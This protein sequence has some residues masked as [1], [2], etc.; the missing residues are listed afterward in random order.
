MEKAENYNETLTR[1]ND[2]LN[3]IDVPKSPVE[4]TVPA[5]TD[6]LGSTAPTPAANSQ[7]S[8]TLNPIYIYGGVPI[9]VLIL[10]LIIQPTFLRDETKDEKGEKKTTLNFKKVVIWTA[11]I[12]TVID[13]GIFAYFYQQKK[14]AKAKAV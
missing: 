3:S 14:A 6:N 5:L 11:V 7:W 8:F 2:Q 10:F 12:S 4:G 9:L 13:V 1:L